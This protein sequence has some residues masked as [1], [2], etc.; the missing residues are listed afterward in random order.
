[1]TKITV[2]TSC[3]N[4]P[5]K[6][7]LRDFNIAFAEGNFEFIIDQVSDEVYW[8]L[9]GEK[10]VRG[11]DNFDAEIKA[12]SQY[13]K[14]KEMIIDSIITHGKEAAANGK[15]VMQDKT[16]AFCDVYK[17]KSASSKMITEIHSYVI[18]V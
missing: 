18:Q 4:S 6:E 13:P 7:M 5:K 8:C 11:K 15:I 2:N 16:Y 9:Y 12:M 1:M 10:E 17:F 14:P 3:K